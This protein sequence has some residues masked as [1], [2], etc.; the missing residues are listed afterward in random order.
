M[1]RIEWSKNIVLF[2][3]EILQAGE[4]FILDYI[5]RSPE[6]Q[7]RL[8]KIGREL[9]EGNWVIVDK[10]KV[11]TYKDGSKNQTEGHLGGKALDMYFVGSDGKI[12]VI[13]HPEWNGGEKYIK[14]QNLWQLKYGGKKAIEWDLNHFE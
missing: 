12:I 11:V 2:L 13:G 10:N 6:E 1:N 3:N 8:F 5:K 7:F 14:W 4:V 9:R